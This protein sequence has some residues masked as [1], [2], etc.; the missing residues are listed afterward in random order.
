[1][2][3]ILNYKLFFVSCVIMTLI[4]GSDTIFILTQSISHNK[5][6]G[7]ST[8]SGICTGLLFH[9]G[10]VALGL[11]AVVKS[12]PTAFQMIKYLG[13]AYLVYLGIRSILSK[14]SLLIGNGD[15]QELPLKK[16]YIQGLIANILNPKVIL[17]FLAFLPQFID[18]ESKNYGIMTYLVLGSTYF[19]LGIIW[20]SVLVY[21]A[22]V[23]A[24]L[25]KKKAGFSKVVNKISG[26]IFILLGLNL[27]IARL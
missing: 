6:V 11:A 1:M 5:K 9:T 17:F 23:V 19:S 2:L 3:G 25:L 8:A 12:S 16:A 20:C 18:V 22:S 13:A 15:T 26:L 14:E 4:P 10:F 24:N 21:F 27:L 7:L